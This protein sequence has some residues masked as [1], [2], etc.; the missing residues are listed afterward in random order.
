MAN[1][2][3]GQPQKCMRCEKPAAYQII[4]I[5]KHGKPYLHIVCVEHGE[6]IS[7]VL[8]K[9]RK[10]SQTNLLSL[11]QHFLNPQEA[12]AA[13]SV[14]QEEGAGA[15]C[16][17]CHLAFNQYRKTL[18][19]GCSDCYSAFQDLLIKDHRKFHGAVSQTPG[20]EESQLPSPEPEV[21]ARE[22]QTEDDKYLNSMEEAAVVSLSALKKQMQEAVKS[23]DF[24]KA[25]R[26]RDSIRKMEGN[27]GKKEKT[28]W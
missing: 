22:P 18:L 3:E 13:E 6:S 9:N 10:V 5:D 28:E 11:I 27:P 21:E 1:A 4:Q 12:E 25:A 15:V 16:P 23:E 26:L 20:S 14:E 2:N 24:E 17:N 19:L 7:R 8:R